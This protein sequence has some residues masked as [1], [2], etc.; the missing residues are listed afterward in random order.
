MDFQP[1]LA[2]SLYAAKEDIS[3]PVGGE[4]RSACR[5]R[6]F[7]MASFHSPAPG[8]PGDSVMFSLERGEAAEA[9]NFRNMKLVSLTVSD[10]LVKYMECSRRAQY[11]S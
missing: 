10:M 7:W 11:R 6:P 8:V 4:S 5:N 1:L 2:R 3:I 9:G